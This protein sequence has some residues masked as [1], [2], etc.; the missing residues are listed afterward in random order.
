MLFEMSRFLLFKNWMMFCRHAYPYTHAH[1]HM[2]MMMSIHSSFGR[3]YISFFPPLVIKYS[4]E[5]GLRKR[6]FVFPMAEGTGRHAREVMGAGVG[7]A[8][9]TAWAVR[10]QRVTD[11]LPAHLLLFVLFLT[12][13]QVT[14]LPTFKV[15]LV[16]L[17]PAWLTSST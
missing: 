3:C 8:G 15:W 10:K 13:A 12:P 1:I 16:N 14:V 2:Y 6:R 11:A 5:R 9:H 17:L 4:G 7:A